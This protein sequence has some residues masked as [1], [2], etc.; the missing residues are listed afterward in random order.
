MKYVMIKW[1][2]AV[3]FLKVISNFF[4]KYFLLF[5]IPFLVMNFLSIEFMYFI[6]QL[7]LFFTRK[8][9]KLSK[10]MFTFRRL[11]NSSYT[12]PTTVVGSLLH[13]VTHPFSKQQIT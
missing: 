3:L 5:I 6:F 7:G 13:N 1:Y 2:M 12:L 8:M 4:K 10:P 11:V 9:T